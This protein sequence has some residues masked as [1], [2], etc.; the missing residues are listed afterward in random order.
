MSISQDIYID[1]TNVLNKQKDAIKE[2]HQK[3]YQ[4]KGMSNAN[5]TDFEGEIRKDIKKIKD[6]NDELSNAY[7]NSNAPST[8]Q[9]NELDR[10][11][12]EIQQLKISIKDEENNFITVVKAKYSYKGNRSGEYTPTEEMKGMTNNELMALQ[13]DKINQQ[14]KK[15]DDITLEVKK[16]KVLAKEAGHI[17]KDQNKQLDLL[18]E[19]IDRLDSRFKKGIKRFENYV[20]K[21]SGCCIIIVLIIELV[22][23]F[24]IYFLLSN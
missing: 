7:S 13:K 16:G 18:Q 24:L 9:M 3:V 5:T 4:L 2:I 20:A 6:K 22:V 11:Q 12:K 17:I 19:D 14:D 1:F 23:A 15:I 10:R 21:Q 8:I